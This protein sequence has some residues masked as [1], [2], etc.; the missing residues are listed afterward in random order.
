MPVP[1]I[2]I[3]LA[4]LLAGG[5]NYLIAVVVTDPSGFA[6]GGVTADN[7]AFKA[8]VNVV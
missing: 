6:D 3:R 8:K 4:G 2:R 1:L 5:T 7:S